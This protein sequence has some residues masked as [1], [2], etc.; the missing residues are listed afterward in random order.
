[1]I[2]LSVKGNAIHAEKLLIMIFACFLITIED[3]DTSSV[4]YAL[5]IVSG[6]PFIDN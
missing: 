4:T 2:M 3:L 1:M 5:G 6:S